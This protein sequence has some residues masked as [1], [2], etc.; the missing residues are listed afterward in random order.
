MKLGN[1]SC[2]SSL[3]LSGAYLSRTV[4]FIVSNG[5]MIYYELQDAP[6]ELLS[7]LFLR[8]QEKQSK[9]HSKALG[10]RKRRPGV[11]SQKPEHMPV[12][13]YSTH[14]LVRNPKGPTQSRY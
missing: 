3:I 13:E 6:K 4:G 7:L 5:R 2:V 1:K 10:C 11:L 14:I 12:A 9:I 8:W